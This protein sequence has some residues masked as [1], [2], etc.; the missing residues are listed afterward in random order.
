MEPMKL[1]LVRFAVNTNTTRHP[2]DVVAS[3]RFPRAVGNTYMRWSLGSVPGL[4]SLVKF[5]WLS[6]RVLDADWVMPLGRR[7]F[8]RVAFDRQGFLLGLS[9]HCVAA[10]DCGYQV[11]RLA[12]T[13]VNSC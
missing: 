2:S 9:Q 5:D 13:V 3:L 1:T 12:G 6:H 4:Y 10:K 11:T 8:A 7:G